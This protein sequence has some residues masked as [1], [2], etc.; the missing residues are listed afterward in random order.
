MPKDKRTVVPQ[1][2]EKNRQVYVDPVEKKPVN[3][4]EA[5]KQW[6]EFGDKQRTIGET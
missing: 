5:I 2:R 1:I 4:Y 6:L 3:S